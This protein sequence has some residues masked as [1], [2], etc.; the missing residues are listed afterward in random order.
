M[1]CDFE[2]GLC[3][4]DIRTISPLKWTRTN[5]MNISLSEPQKGPGRDHSTNTMTGMCGPVSR[6][7]IVSKF[8]F[9]I[10]YLS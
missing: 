8:S 7:I 9:I 1:S 5:Q 3:G 10:I 6:V 4:W 2:D